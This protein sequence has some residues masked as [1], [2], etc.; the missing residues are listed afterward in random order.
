MCL[1]AEP[2]WRRLIDELEPLGLG[3][4]TAHAKKESTLA[5]RLGIHSLPCLVVT[6]DG[7]TSVYKESLFSI[8]KVV[9]TFAAIKMLYISFLVCCLVL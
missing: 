6:V 3:L 7:R 5:R 2:T 1:Q 4:A 8:Q 9:G